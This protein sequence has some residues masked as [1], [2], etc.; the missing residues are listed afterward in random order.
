M[1]GSSLPKVTF[2]AN[3]NGGL[4]APFRTDMV[5]TFPTVLLNIGGAFNPANGVFT[6]PFAGVYQFNV[7][8]V[9]DFN[10]GVLLDFISCYQILK[11]LQHKLVKLLSL[12]ARSNVSIY[13]KVCPRLYLSS[14]SLEDM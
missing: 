10:K 5:I 7:N 13:D 12:I 2:F 1:A 3:N 9:A 4:N 14:H 8:V 11:P 6:A